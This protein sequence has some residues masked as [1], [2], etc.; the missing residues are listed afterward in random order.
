MT[1]SF[2]YV[3]DVPQRYVL[4][5][6]Q[7]YRRNSPIVPD[8]IRM[9]TRLARLE[10][11]ANPEKEPQVVLQRVRGGRGVAAPFGFELGEHR[12]GQ[13]RARAGVDVQDVIAWVVERRQ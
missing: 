2:R 7:P 6:R 3:G 8:A 10:G 1:D 13:L 11:P 9:S 5:R 12:L 4:A